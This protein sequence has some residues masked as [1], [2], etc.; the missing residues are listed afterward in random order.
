MLPDYRSVDRLNF[1]CTGLSTFCHNAK[2]KLEHVKKAYLLVG[3]TWETELSKID[4]KMIYAVQK[5][6][7]EDE[8]YYIGESFSLDFARINE[9]EII[10][11]HSILLTLQNTLE[12]FLDELCQVVAY[13]MN[14]PIKLTD[15]NGH[16]IP[17][18]LKY[19]SKIA[20]FKLK[21]VQQER[22]IVMSTQ[23]IRNLIVHAGGK[24]PEDKKHKSVILIKNSIYFNGIPGHYITIKPEFIEY[25]IDILVSFFEKLHF[26]IQ[27]FMERAS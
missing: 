19:L 6:A 14:S 3:S 21:S 15:Q 11:R 18:A 23:Q 10:H 4:N 5:A 17:R 25:Y 22:Q 20:K 12:H 13:T 16:G 9:F 8:Q 1:F 24:I 26:E 7:D 2:N 27:E